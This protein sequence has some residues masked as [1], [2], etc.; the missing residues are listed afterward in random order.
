MHGYNVSR[1][2]ASQ[3]G[4]PGVWLLLLVTAICFLIYFSART[5]VWLRGVFALNFLKKNK[6][7]QEKAEGEVH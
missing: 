6:D 7:G 4:A 2:L 5:V 1:W 3:V